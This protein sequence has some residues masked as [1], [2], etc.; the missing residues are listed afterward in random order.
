MKL[1]EVLDGMLH[2][3]YPECREKRDRVYSRIKEECK[4]LNKRGL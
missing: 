4:R 1:G 3:W 2:E